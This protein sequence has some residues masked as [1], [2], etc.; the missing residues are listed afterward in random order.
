[1]IA[2]RN[3]PTLATLF[4]IGLAVAGCTAPP[5]LSRSSQ[6]ESSATQEATPP[7]SESPAGETETAKAAA[8][9][10]PSR[11]GTGTYDP[12][13]D[14]LVNP[15]AIF[16]PM[17]EDPAKLASDQTLIRHI[18]SGPN[19][20]N[21]IFWSTHYDD[22]A[23]SPLYDGYVSWDKDFNWMMNPDMVTSHTASEDQ[24]IWTLHLR[25]D[26]KW[27]DGAPLTTED[28]RFTWQAILDEN[29]P[30]FTFKDDAMKVEDIKALDPH[31]VQIAIRDSL[32]IN[33]WVIAFPIIPK[34][35]FDT[36]R[37]AEDPTMRTSPYYTRF[38]RE[39]VVGNGPYKL[40][41]WIPNDKLVYERW[42]DYPGEK[43][44][45]KRII[46]K[47][48]SDRSTALQLFRKGDHD[49]ME[50]TPLQF[51]FETNDPAFA[52]VGNKIYAPQWLH[53]FIIW[54]IRNEE[55]C[56]F[57]GELKVRQA[58]AHALNIPYIVKEYGY[59]LVTP[60]YGIF[61]PDAPMFNPD[62]KRLEYDL[63]EAG[64]LLDE[65][66]W[67]RDGT[68]GWR[69]KQVGGR[70][71]QLSFTISI[72]QGST[73]GPK[74]AALFAEDLKKIGVD[75]KQRTI[76]FA[77]L[78]DMLKKHDFQAYIGRVGT[79]VY[80]DT[81]ENMWKTSMYD[82]GRNYG[83]Y[84]NARVDELFELATHEF[85][86]NKR[87]EHF[88]EIQKLIYDDQPFLFI[89]NDATTEIVGNKIRGLE[90]SPRGV[91]GFHPSWLRWWAPAGQTMHA[92]P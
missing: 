22:E 34:H 71:A 63:K 76:E 19:T 78:I 88:R 9:S 4:T 16:E 50:V 48:Q 82:D 25:E 17:P 54:N 13:K 92:M 6:T 70:R 73:M 20:L 91:T 8:T 62:I 23:Q 11:P 66:G 46:L 14:P 60:S 10:A 45:F 39:E 27:H 47:I 74:V 58:L 43:P 56:P 44:Y 12:K 68:D 26:L 72:P 5:Q 79:G 84:G 21:P 40:V 31:T 57:F 36:A 89:Y 85:D 55:A 7:A 3:L 24:R 69:Y 90:L 80:P 30:A 53:S 77:T 65:A 52:A 67:P 18:A 37:R 59:S 83:G 29:V 33:K 87:M 49:H 35:I 81:Q 51:A 32:P 28:F 38:N 41:E 2:R 61:H 64:R 75:M 86:E 15:P 1:V 42:E